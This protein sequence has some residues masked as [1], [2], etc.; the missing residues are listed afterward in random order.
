ML[1]FFD[2]NCMI[3]SRGVYFKNTVY[4][5]NGILNKMDFIGIKKALA[6][7][8]FSYEYNP[9]YGNKQIIKET[10]DEDKLLPVWAV[11]PNS[12]NEFICEE[13]LPREM[14]QNDVKFVRMSPETERFS[15]SLNELVSGKLLSVLEECSI[16]ILM[17]YDLSIYNE[18]V[19]MLSNHPN[20]KI[21]FL[22]TGYRIN[23]YFYPLMEN[24]KNVYVE[25]SGFKQY[26]GI[27]GIVKTFGAERLIFGSG[28][29]LFST[30]SAVTMITHADIKSREKE[31]IAYKNLENLLE[32]V[33]I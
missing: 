30:G 1:E 29:P 4:E 26:M 31:M 18:I 7:S 24:F 13:D 8:S 16:P 20:L 2:C 5:K 12:C 17:D 22:N 21:I 10:K 27:E 23:R 25:T 9:L 3:G 15:H 19:D 6:T 33:Q 11:L 14:K 28:M 32:G